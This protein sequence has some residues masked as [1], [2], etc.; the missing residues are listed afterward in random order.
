M[1]DQHIR[2]ALGS[3]ETALLRE[4]GEYVRQ[5]QGKKLRPMLLMLAARL[6]GYEGDAHTKVAAAIEIIHTA[7]LLHDDVIDHAPLRR[8]RP[9]VNAR[10]GNDVAILIG[11]FLY[12]CAFDLALQALSPRVL[13]ILCQVTGR[14]CEGEMFQIE[15]GDSLLTSN[16]YL[17]IV[18]CKTAY[19]FSACTALGSVLANS[20][21]DQV[22]RL[23]EY[24]LNF[25]IAFQI[26]D[27]TLD[28]VADDG[29]L[30]KQHWTDIRNGKQTLPFIHTVEV[31][32]ATDRADL[33][34][35]WNNG[36]DPERIMRHIRKY[37]GVEYAL[38]QAR[39]FAGE[40]RQ[41]LSHM[42]ESK[43]TLLFRELSDYVVE[44]TH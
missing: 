1:V 5:G 19:L 16:D 27:D 21:E 3:S 35:C 15:K 29:D 36:R 33:W 12:S 41:S 34:A 25:G 43:E 24:G 38:G 9:T 23:T 14:M 2:T 22:A 30:G 44:R 4:V 37:N 20:D 10:W 32:D 42:P 7:T 8:N 31:A 17:H 40:A 6:A 26:T 28:L 39:S 11:D 18:R 13:T